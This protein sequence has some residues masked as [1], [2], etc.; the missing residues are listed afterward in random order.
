M[1]LGGRTPVPQ[2]VGL[3]TTS[4]SVTLGWNPMTVPGGAVSSYN[5]YRSNSSGGENY[6]APLA[7]GISATANTFT[8]STVSTQSNYYYV[9]RPVSGGVCRINFKTN[10]TPPMPFV[11]TANKLNFSANVWAQ[12]PLRIFI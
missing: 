5:I 1:A 3:A 12:S 2:A 9:V 11:Y 7:T 6:S 8:D 4:A 10:K